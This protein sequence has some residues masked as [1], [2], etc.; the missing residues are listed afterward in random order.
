MNKSENI[1]SIDRNVLKKLMHTFRQPPFS[2]WKCKVFQR[3]QSIFQEWSA[4]RIGNF[5]KFKIYQ[6]A[7]EECFKES[8]HF[9]NKTD[10]HHHHICIRKKWLNIYG[11]KIVMLP[12]YPIKAL[13]L[14]MFMYQ[15]LL[16]SLC[17]ISWNL[18]NL[19]AEQHEL[20]RRLER[21]VFKTLH[22]GFCFCLLQESASLLRAF[23]KSLYSSVFKTIFEAKRL[24]RKYYCS[25]KAKKGLCFDWNCC[26]LHLK[27]LN[28][29]NV[30]TLCK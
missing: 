27:L 8:M 20:L 15:C 7:K 9:K 25:L 21:N 30:I 18:L 26:V 10:G 29:T 2:K 3:I 12:W 5:P 14:K 17:S 23:V 22:C 28:F 19:S 6:N 4:A 24:L 13:A 11:L 16:A 1:I